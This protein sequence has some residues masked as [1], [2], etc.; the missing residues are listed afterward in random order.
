M[1]DLISREEALAYPLSFDHYDKQ[2]GNKHFINGVE[3]YREYIEGLPTVEQKHGHWN[4]VKVLKGT[5]VE[6]HNT[7]KCSVCGYEKYS[8]RLPLYCEHCG[9]EMDEKCEE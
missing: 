9:A 2:N 4:K 6:L 3:S 1:S 5:K 8:L 7:I